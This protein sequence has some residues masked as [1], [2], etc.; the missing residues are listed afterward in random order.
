VKAMILAGINP[1][2]ALASV[3]PSAEQPAH[4]TWLAQQVQSLVA[5]RR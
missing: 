1:E 3:V 4:V 5:E 2:A